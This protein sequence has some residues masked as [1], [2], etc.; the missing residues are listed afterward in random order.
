M[1]IFFEAGNK[2]FL[3]FLVGDEL[4]VAVHEVS[5]HFGVS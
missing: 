4:D 1:E 2:Y 3:D 5:N